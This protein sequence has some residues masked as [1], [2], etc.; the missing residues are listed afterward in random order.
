MFAPAVTVHPEAHVCVLLL[1]AET[2]KS[3]LENW[4]I[5]QGGKIRQVIWQVRYASKYVLVIANVN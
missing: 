2:V 5:G 1:V 4:W 3:V